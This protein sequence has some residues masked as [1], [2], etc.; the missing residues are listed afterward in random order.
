MKAEAP[1]EFGTSS[2][3]STETVTRIIAEILYAIIVV[4][5]FI[6]DFWPD[7][8]KANRMPANKYTGKIRF[9]KRGAN[10]ARARRER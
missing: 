4:F 10:S 8:I 1:N 7:I 9:S 5:R 6:C 3:H 2:P